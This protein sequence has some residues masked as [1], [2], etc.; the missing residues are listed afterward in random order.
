MAC[1]PQRAWRRLEP[2]L[3][4]LDEFQ[5][6]RHLLVD[7]P[8]SEAASLARALFDWERPETGE[9]ARVLM[10]S[11]TPYRALT[12]AGD[13]GNDN[14]HED[15]LATVRF[16]ADSE[17][18]ADELRGLLRDYQRELYGSAPEASERLRALGADIEALLTRY[19]ARTER[20]GAAGQ[21]RRDAPPRPTDRVTHDRRPAPIPARTGRRTRTEAARRHRA[22]EERPIPPELPRRLHAAQP[23]RRRLQVA[24][25]GPG[26]GSAAQR[27]KGRPA[28][29]RA[30]CSL[31]AMSIPAGRGCASS[32]RT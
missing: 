24:R 21:T 23:L 17:T 31:M 30:A 14:H 11:A 10:L 19:I 16:L 9:H 4:I 1:S 2:D 25:T 18:R 5:R 8:D 3:V 6:F 29:P 28:R 32:R 22:L 27:D 20:I 13:G 26:L 15:F 7:D 12:V